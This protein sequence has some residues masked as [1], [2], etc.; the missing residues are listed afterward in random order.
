MLE[1]TEQQY[2]LLDENQQDA[3][4]LPSVTELLDLSNEVMCSCRLSN[5]KNYTVSSLIVHL[6]VL[7]KRWWH[8][9]APLVWWLPLQTSLIILCNSAPHDHCSGRRRF[10][11]TIYVPMAEGRP[12]FVFKMTWECFHY[13]L[14]CSDWKV[15][16]L[17]NMLFQYQF[18]KFDR[19]PSGFNSKRINHSFANIHEGI[20]KLDI[21]AMRDFSWSNWLFIGCKGHIIVN[22]SWEETLDYLGRHSPSRHPRRLCFYTIFPSILDSTW[23]MV[24]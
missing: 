13:V 24:L 10:Q 6:L 21:E 4:G 19:K 17:K 2:Y 22:R 18:V 11:V 1:H 16:A 8:T 12:F 5:C 23:W 7:S 3:L 9:P 20:L 15:N 14:K